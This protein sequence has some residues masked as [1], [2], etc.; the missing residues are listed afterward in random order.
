MSYFI[1]LEFLLFKT[2]YKVLITWSNWIFFFFLP[3]KFSSYYL[4]NC[5]WR[6]YFDRPFSRDPTEIKLIGHDVRNCFLVITKYLF[7][8]HKT[9]SISQTFPMITRKQCKKWFL[10]KSTMTCSSAHRFKSLQSVLV[11]WFLTVTCLLN[12]IF[13]TCRVMVCVRYGRGGG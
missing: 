3:S 12:C 10:P 4:K 7:N 5:S 2:R 9:Q 11:C 6:W 13:C 8:V 1:F